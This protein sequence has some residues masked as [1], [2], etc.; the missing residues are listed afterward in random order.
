MRRRTEM[1]KTCIYRPVNRDVL[2]R[3]EAEIADPHMEGHFSGWRACHE[4]DDTETV[5]EGFR[6]KHGQHCTPVQIAARLGL[7]RR[8]GGESDV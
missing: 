7:L 1:C 6:L 4:A 8:A 2:P 3:L 5:C